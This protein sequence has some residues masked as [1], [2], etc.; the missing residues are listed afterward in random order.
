MSILIFSGVQSWVKNKLYRRE[1]PMKYGWIWATL[2]PSTD[3]N[4]FYFAVFP[5]WS[6]YFY[7]ISVLSPSLYC[8][9]LMYELTL[10]SGKYLPTEK[11]LCTTECSF[12]V[13]AVSKQ[14]Y[15]CC[16]L[17]SPIAH[18]LHVVKSVLLHFIITPS[19][20]MLAMENLPC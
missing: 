8:I 19:L 15:S 3:N 2:S 14:D 17:G 13:T 6:I 1:L 7:N 12:L 9:L 18:L 20:F 11:W 16:P 4:W 10:I 5:A